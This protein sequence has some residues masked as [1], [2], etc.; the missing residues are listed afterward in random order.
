MRLFHKLALA[1]V[2]M[3][4]LAMLFPISVAIA[5][6]VVT[7]PDPNL[8]AAIRAW[9]NKP[10]GEIYQSDLVGLTSLDA[11][12][13]GIAVLTGLEHCT[14][15]TGLALYR[16]QISNISPLS[17]LTNLT[18]LDLGGNQLSDISPLAGLT[19][20][21]QLQLHDNQISDIS[22]FAGLPNLTE[23][24]LDR[25]PL[26]AATY[27]YHI[28]QL[29]ARG[30]TVYYTDPNT[31][32]GSNV[33]VDLVPY[34][35]GVATVRFDNVSA[36][37]N[38]MVSETMPNLL[39]IPPGYQV[40]GYNMAITTGAEYSGNVEIALR[41][42]FT[43]PPGVPPPPEVANEN[44]L[45]L[46]H[47]E[48]GVW[49]DVT[50]TVDTVNDIL[51]G[52]VTLLGSFFMAEFT[53]GP[54]PPPPPMQV[55]HLNFGPPTFL[56]NFNA[57]PISFQPGDEIIQF[58][59]PNLI[60]GTNPT[61]S[62]ITAGRWST[63]VTGDL[64]GTLIADYNVIR[65]TWDGLGTSKGYAI[66][67]FTFNDGYGN[68]FS[69]VWVGDMDF[70]T[71]FQYP[72]IKYYV[73]STSGTGI[74]SGQV[75]IGTMSGY[76]NAVNA[77]T[78]RRYASSEVSGP[79]P[80]SFSGTSTVGGTRSL[81]S[82]FFGG[83]ENDE[84]IQF[85][86]ANIVVPKDT[87][88]FYNEGILANG[89]VTGALTGTMT[90]NHNGIGI[91]PPGPGGCGVGTFSYSD[92]SGTIRGVHVHD[93]LQLP[94]PPSPA[95]GQGYLFAMAETGIT[96]V[97]SGSEYFITYN[98]TGSSSTY[99][100]TGNLYTLT[101]GGQPPTPTP[102]PTPTPNTPTPNTPAGSNV[103]VPLPSTVVTFGNVT[104]EGTTSVNWSAD[105][106]GGTTPPNFYVHGL[107]MNISTTA[108]YTD[109]VNVCMGYDESGVANENN[110]RLFHWN[111]AIWEDV[112]TLP[113]DTVNNIICGDM[114]TLSPFFVGEPAAQV[115]TA[116]GT[117][118]ARFS[119]SSGAIE[120][121]TAVTE[122]SLPTEGKPSLVF[123][124]GF[125]RFDITGLS[126]GQ[127]VTVV[128]ELPSNIRTNSQYWKWDSTLG[129]HSIG[130]SDNDG[131][132]I[133]AIQLTDN[134]TGDSDPTP[135]R[136][137]D[138]GGP[139]NPSGGG[140]GG[141]G[142]GCFIA[143]AAYGSSLDSHVDT[144]RSFR[145]QYLE[146]NPIGSAFVSLYY[147]VSPPM[148]EFINEHPALKP[149]VRAGLVPAV[150][151]STV[152]V[153]TTPMEK[154]AIASSLAFVCILVFVGLRRKIIRGK[155]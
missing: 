50:T 143:T 54:P 112:T 49:K 138:D 28:P 12:S 131:D 129:W 65:A 22:Q 98:M 42:N 135:G 94:I 88:A 71:G 82:S 121:L 102:T 145:D 32:A 8:Q 59:R 124:H 9:I 40:F 114:T 10:F 142:G 6:D 147:K 139:G 132:R 146:T 133:I 83:Q 127:T 21:I 136:I 78:L 3:S 108:T 140:G 85:T 122:G 99:S 68:T 103:T 1:I 66:V 117:G 46:L 69:G 34:V 151:M 74:F 109:T 141:G 14:N 84:F 26:N 93:T 18:H 37:G 130:F 24:R 111:G 57:R 137:H 39:A 15:L 63:I 4:L 134:G 70:F 100:C 97:Y 86:R 90:H 123:P 92:G 154:I 62:F 107:F 106:P 105:N 80:I 33:V 104:G 126:N 17:G 144:L 29:Q 60:V 77:M 45:R 96:G 31:P 115:Q 118:T 7:F 53:G 51:Y 43:L 19:N 36:K 25:N 55:L 56:Q 152:A 52:R 64:S 113:V 110:L 61:A 20:L 101:P 38:T 149:I 48:G 30:V 75:L 11:P 148:A 47:W 76:T 58:T 125:F 41:Y 16:N 116:T 13:R 27:D 120:N 73:V 23:L 87:P 5:D 95:T 81:G 153:D 119:V 35:P 128:M 72:I 89:S 2:L 155:F 79:D 150:V 67:T 44:G 91:A